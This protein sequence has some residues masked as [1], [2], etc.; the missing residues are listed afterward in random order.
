MEFNGETAQERRLYLKQFSQIDISLDRII[1][2]DKSA[3]LNTDEDFLYLRI[4]LDIVVNTSINIIKL[5]SVY[6]R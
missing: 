2:F 6:I 5:S 1:I 4:R 3:L